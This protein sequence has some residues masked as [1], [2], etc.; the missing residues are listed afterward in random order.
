MVEI[1]EKTKKTSLVDLIWMTNKKTSSKRYIELD[2]LRGLAILLMIFGHILWDLDYFGLVKINSTLYSILQYIVPPLF[3]ILVGMSIIA[4]RKNH[5]FTKEQEKKYYEKMII[6]GLKIFN[7]GMFLTI[8]SLFAMPETPVYFGVL[9]CIGISIILSTIF[10]KYKHYNFI[11]AVLILSLSVLFSQI[12]LQNPSILHM[13][14]GIH[15]ADIWKYTVDYFPL[16]PWFGLTLLGM[17]IG[18]ILYVKEKRSFKVPSFSYLRPVKLFS[19]FGRHSLEIY[20]IHQPV[21]AGFLYLFIKV[22]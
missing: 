16:V 13:V 2:L 4:G 10:L 14:F 19:W 21:I 15:Q 6:R 8:A 22:L 11:F 1:I 12:H 9:H 20:L 18:N 7:L 5:T 17:G 3:F